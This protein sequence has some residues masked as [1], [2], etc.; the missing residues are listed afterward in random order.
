M[1]VK[2]FNNEIVECLIISNLLTVYVILYNCLDSDKCRRNS[3]CAS[4]IVRLIFLTCNLEYRCVCQTYPL[5]IE[6]ARIYMTQYLATRCIADTL[7]STRST[8]QR[9]GCDQKSF[10]LI[11]VLK[12]SFQFNKIFKIIAF[13]HV[14]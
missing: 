5:P 7:R 4:S 13:T 10:S 3:L 11:N 6:N 8:L 12:L 9:Q 2:Q 1:N 14:F